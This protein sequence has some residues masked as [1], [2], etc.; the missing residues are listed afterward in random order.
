MNFKNELLY[1]LRLHQ[2]TASELSRRSGVS[3]QSISDWLA[4]VQPRSFSQVKKIADTFGVSIEALVFG[5]SGAVKEKPTR[6]TEQ[7][8]VP[9]QV[10]Q[11][12][13]QASPYDED[14][15]ISYV[16]GFDGFLKGTGKALSETLGWSSEELC[17]RPFF[18]FVHFA[19]RVRTQ[20]KMTRQVH[21]AGVFVTTDSRFLCKGGDIK[22]LRWSAI[23]WPEDRVIYVTSKDITSKY[24]KETDHRVQV[25]LSLL[26][27]DA[28]TFCNI[29]PLSEGINYIV[30][31]VSPDVL[32]VCRLAQMS[33]AMVGVMHQ[34]LM[35]ILR[36]KTSD[37]RIDLFEAESHVCVQVE[38]LADNRRPNLSVPSYLIQRE[39]GSLISE[40]NERLRFYLRMPKP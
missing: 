15:V 26:I 24:P 17:D 19:D 4:G 6:P 29:H 10:Y 21:G 30:P 32:V 28:V 18:E 40:F 33:S 39:G 27:H 14:R 20:V 25:S 38:V 37:I 2:I 9:V 12:I 34:A 13:P 5:Q 8:F 23:A 3:K 1:Y 7:R 16:L 36:E 22:W 31:S 11:S 35:C